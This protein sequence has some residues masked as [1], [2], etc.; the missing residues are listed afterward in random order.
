MA[1]AKEKA[2]ASPAPPA[3]ADN[4]DKVESQDLPK[5]TAMEA[6]KWGLE[7]PEILRH[8][9]VEERAVLEKKLR[10][11][12]DFRLLPM[13]IVMYILNYIDRNNIAAARFAGLEE[14]LNMDEAGTQFSTAVSI[15][16]VG[17][18]LMQVPSNLILNK[19]GKPAI[20]LPASMIL[21]GVISAATA[22]CD[23]V[24]G[25]YA[26]RF[27]LGFVEATYF[28]A[29]P[30]CLF[31]LSCWYTRQELGVRTTYLYSGSLISGAFS[32]LISAGIT[33]NMDGLRGLRAWRWLFLLEGVVTVAV[34]IAA[35]FIL[36]NL[37]RTTSWL[38]EEEAALASWRL[39]EDIG[40]DDW[41]NS[42]E[43]TLWH[44][45]KL[46]I[47]DVK[48]WVLYSNV[49]TLL[50]TTPPYVLG[51]IT[52]FINAWHADKTGERFFHVTI[53][54]CLA[55]VVFIISAATINTAARYV[56]MML[57]ISGLY[58]GYTTALAWISNTL[59]RPPAKRA[60]ALGLINAVSNCASI[61][62]S[63]LY[64]SSAS[65]RYTGAFIHNCVMAAV[66]IAAAFV[67]RLMLARLN[68]KLD[69]GE[70]VEGAIN[71][72]PG[73]AVEHGFRFRL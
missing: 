4:I 12:I 1:E 23:S 70:R 66:A 65:P 27:F 47:E 13:I 11:K 39:E 42:E 14:D 45:F 73:E 51:V 24:G 54:L 53:P 43:Q 15:L 58:S 57:M 67:L 72:T 18:I 44:G 62:A 7:P 19:I 30:G 37:P 46:A 8:L 33:G 49:I 61:Y 17:Y 56:A 59:P 10:R 28:N 50:L 22:A 6:K 69:K 35:F 31:Y 63:Y 34:A 3:A 32:G 48:V 26:S 64:P 16:F 36:P 5:D 68:K 20:Y 2:A 9:T 38:T 40:S 52:T 21:W 71:A 29:K 55:V 60:A 41:T 25:L